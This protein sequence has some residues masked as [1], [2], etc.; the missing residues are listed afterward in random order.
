MKTD[1]IGWKPNDALYHAE[2]TALLRAAGANG[3]SLSG[4]TLE[5][6][7]DR[8]MCRSCDKILPLVNQ[9]IGNPTVNF[10]DKHGARRTLRNGIWE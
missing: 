1:N 10:K 4:R 2:T 7:V 9:E 6:Y 5:I 3:G 8:E